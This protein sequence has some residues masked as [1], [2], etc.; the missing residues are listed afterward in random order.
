MMDSNLVGARKLR[1]NID[2][3]SSPGGIFS[4]Q[5]VSLSLG[6]EA[7]RRFCTFS[8]CVTLPVVTRV[9]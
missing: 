1:K 6:S 2:N 3:C 5:G 8:S 9:Q 7:W 4:T